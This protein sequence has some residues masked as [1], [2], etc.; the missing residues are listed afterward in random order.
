VPAVTAV[1][2]LFQCPDTSV[3]GT[4][5][6]ATEGNQVLA[7]MDKAVQ[8]GHDEEETDQIVQPLH[9][10][11]STERNHQTCYYIIKKILGY[12]WR[13]QIAL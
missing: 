13:S 1:S 11:T 5:V 8:W 2:E 6:V 10:M 9:W 7:T 3:D 12:S 4:P